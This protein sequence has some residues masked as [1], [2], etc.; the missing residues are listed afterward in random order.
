MRAAF[1]SPAR[2]VAD[3]LLIDQSSSWP[4]LSLEGWGDKVGGPGSCL[5]RRAGRG[6]LGCQLKG[7]VNDIVPSLLSQRVVG[8]SR[9]LLVLSKR[10]GVAVV[11]RVGLV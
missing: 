4:T 7:I 1:H 8:A 5:G 11:V 3:T 9:E 2:S 10:L 6:V